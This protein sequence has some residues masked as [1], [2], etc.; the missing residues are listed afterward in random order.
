MNLVS[1]SDKIQLV[2]G[3]ALAVD[4]Q[5]SYVDYNGTTVTPDRKNTAISTAATTDVV[6]AP[7]SGVFRKVKTLAIRNKDASSSQTVTARHTDGTTTVD[8]IVAT[9][10]AGEALHYVAEAGWMVFDALG[11]VKVTSI[12]NTQALTTSIEQSPEQRVFRSALSSHPVAAVGGFVMIS[13]TAY[14]VY[15]GRAV[16]DLT[17]A[18]VEF[19]VT[20][21]GA[22]AQTAEVGIFTTPTAPAKSAQTL[23]KVAATGTL[24]ALT[25]TGVMRNTS[26]L[27]AAI[28][29]GQHIWAA[30]RTAMATT[31]PTVCALNAADMSEGHILTT[32][33]QGAL[34]GLTTTAGGLVAVGTAL[35]CPDLRVTLD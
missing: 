23:T 27:A 5:A 16:K 14:Y 13:G 7:G 19:H 6:L 22:G 31:Q 10:L 4:V 9:L 8:L 24:S 26:T 3:S 20:G 33:A 18:F 2:T 28:K 12:G 21:A 11:N 25:G 34:T 1:T 30:L 35:T 15:I 29:A 32:T 17:I